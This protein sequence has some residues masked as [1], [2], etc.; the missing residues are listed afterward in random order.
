MSWLSSFLGVDA[1]NN[2]NK[3]LGQQT[4]LL[5]QQ[6]A[7]AQQIGAQANP[8]QTNVLG[9]LYKNAT[10]PDVYGASW[11]SPRYAA[12]EDATAPAYDNAVKNTF[13]D[14][15]SR[16]L[17]GDSSGLDAQ[18]AQTRRS[19]ASDLSGFR[20]NLMVQGQQEQQN[21]LQSLEGD[22]GQQQGLAL[23]GMSSAAGGLGGVAGMYNSQANDAINNILGTAK[24]AAAI[25][26]GQPEL[27]ASPT[28]SQTAGAAP[29]DP[30]AIP[31]A[32]DVTGGAALTGPSWTDNSSYYDPLGGVRMT[33][34]YN[35][36]GTRSA[37][38]GDNTLGTNQ[39]G[40]PIPMM[41]GS[42]A[43]V[44]SVFGTARNQV[45]NATPRMFGWTR[46]Y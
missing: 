32:A 29:T 30:S 40:S 24:T 45:A 18:V 6:A 16:G 43:G 35:S 28:K 46:G 36:D 21:R 10:D 27:A 42:G 7:M 12:Y 22:L 4:G 11:S 41:G 26:T 1:R 39:S 8:Y 14:F 19:E 17:T 23:N 2:A 44:P 13:A 20:R 25:Y 37:S 33:G 15:A 38:A 31:I 34:G 9:D 3:T 5:Q